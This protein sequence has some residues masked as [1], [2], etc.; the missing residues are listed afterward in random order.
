MPVVIN[1][2]EAVAEPSAQRSP[3]DKSAAPP[4]LQPAM[5]QIPLMRLEARRLRLKAH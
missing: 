1:D 2:F 4:K 3:D 5:L